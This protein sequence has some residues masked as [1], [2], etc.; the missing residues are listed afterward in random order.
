M[1]IKAFKKRSLFTT[2]CNNCNKTI[3]KFEK[4]YV[5][6]HGEFIEYKFCENCVH[7]LQEAAN[8]STDKILATR[9]VFTKTLD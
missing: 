8:L 3:K 4:M 9:P 1:K 5:V 7:S 6:S 2:R